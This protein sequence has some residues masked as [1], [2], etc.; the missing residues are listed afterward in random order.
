MK[1]KNSDKC[2]LRRS[3]QTCVK[4]KINFDLDFY[5]EYIGMLT[6]EDITI[7][8]LIVAVAD[9]IAQRHHDVE[10]ALE[11]KIIEFKELYDV[12]EKHYG[13][14]FGENKNE[15]D[16]IKEIEDNDVIVRKLSSF[17]VNI[18]TY[19]AIK[20]IS[21]FLIS[22]INEKS[23]DSH[24]KFMKSK[25]NNGFRED[26]KKHINIED[27]IKEKDKKFQNYV[28]NRILN[29]HKAQSMD[30]KGKYIIRELFKAYLTNPQQLPDKTISKIFENLSLKDDSY[31]GDKYK[32][33]GECRNQLD[34]LHSSENIIYERVLMRTICDYI[35][36]MTDRYA[37]E[38]YSGLY[39]TD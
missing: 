39:Q 23:L 13:S 14:I 3:G 8:A 27:D 38:L 36:G 19:N 5:N 31:K 21:N 1:I 37:M 12:L 9:E 18:L 26:L 33:I 4:T 20:N 24:E 25:L 29:S 11:A 32:T 6:E 10:D 2:M 22:L 30:G 35:A 15:Y 17:I 28:K 7:E 16:N 34:K